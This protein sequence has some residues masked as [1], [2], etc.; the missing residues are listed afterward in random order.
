MHFAGISCCG[1]DNVV[2]YAGSLLHS[3]K[4][5]CIV[6]SCGL[7]GTVTNAPPDGKLLAVES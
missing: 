7:I 1:W 2:A 6:Y 3:G 4:Y 5:S